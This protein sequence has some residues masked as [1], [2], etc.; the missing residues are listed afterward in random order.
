MLIAPS[1]HAPIHPSTK[2]CLVVPSLESCCYL[3]KK[4]QS[5]VEPRGHLKNVRKGLAM[6]EKK[7]LLGIWY[8]PD[9][10]PS[11]EFPETISQGLGEGTILLKRTS[12]Q[13]CSLQGRCVWKYSVRS[14]TAHTVWDK[15][16]WAHRLGWRCSQS[17]HS[18]EIPNWVQHSRLGHHQTCWRMKMLLL[19]QFCLIRL[20]TQL[21]WSPLR[22]W[23]QAVSGCPIPGPA[24]SSGH[25]C[26]E[27]QPATAALADGT[28]N[29][30]PSSSL[31]KSLLLQLLL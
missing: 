30:V 15:L 24:G 2:D 20:Q 14:R 6:W 4:L 28:L 19:M 5:R 25:L 21:N 1:S 8:Y 11:C 22:T 27:D 26:L 12:Y 31:W 17:F 9:F 3:R 29:N 13:A 16:C 10:L 7:T 18:P 23:S